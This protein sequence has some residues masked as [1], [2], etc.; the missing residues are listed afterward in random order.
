MMGVPFRVSLPTYAYIVEFHSDGRFFGLA[1]EQPRN[2]WPAGTQTREM[3]ADPVAMSSLVSY[4]S[5]N[6]PPSLCGIHVIIWYQKT[7]MSRRRAIRCAPV[8]PWQEF[9]SNLV[10]QSV[11]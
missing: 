11:R 2:G 3:S 6:A 5:T 4:W 7:G 10:F 1:A 9:Q 8:M